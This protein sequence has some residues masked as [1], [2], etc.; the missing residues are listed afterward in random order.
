MG[1]IICT[2]CL[3]NEGLRIEAEKISKKN[4]EDSCNNCGNR[5]GFE[6]NTINVEEI[7]RHFFVK[8]STPLNCGGNAPVY[9]FNIYDHES[10]IHEPSSYHDASLI[11]KVFGLAVFRY[12]PQMWRLGFTNYFG[13][14]DNEAEIIMKSSALMECCT[15]K[16]MVE[17][18]KLFRVRTNLKN[19]CLNNNEYDTPT[20]LLKKGIYNRFDS[21][22]IDI[23]Y[24]CFDIETCIHESKCI[25][26][27]ELYLATMIV[28][29]GLRILDLTE[30][31]EE[32]VVT[33][34]DS[35]VPTIHQITKTV[36]E[37]IFQYCRILSRQ[38]KIKGYDGFIYPS[39]YSKVK[40]KYLRNIAL[41]GFPIMD[42]RLSV[43]SLNRVRILKVN[44]DYGLGPL[45]D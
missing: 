9:Q 1:K 45:L 3:R 7:M 41:F 4:I 31:K 10:D 8:G 5:G 44:Y 19:D 26:D 12:A 43:I 38:I 13:F 32:N 27:D 30:V 29:K 11:K 37:N 40:D 22:D 39:F 15:D 42:N 16:Y 6:I 18:T 21:E 33:M 34:F 28:N 24:S 2:N 20:K 25:I 23:F 35:V 36:G 14:D 17:G